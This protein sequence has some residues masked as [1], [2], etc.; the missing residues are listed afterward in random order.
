MA[1]PTANQHLNASRRINTRVMPAYVSGLSPKRSP[2]ATG[3]NNWYDASAIT[4]TSND[5]TVQTWSDLSGNARD[6]AQATAGLRPFYYTQALNGKPG[7]WFNNNRSMT[8]T[9]TTPAW[10]STVGTL[11]IALSVHG[12]LPTPIGEVPFSWTNGVDEYW[13]YG[14]ATSYIGVMRSA[15]L[16]G[17]SINFT[18]GYHVITVL[19]GASAYNVYD[20]GATLYTGSSS[21]GVPA[22]GIIGRNAGSAAFFNGF[23]FEILFYNTE[24]DAATL[25]STWNY[26]KWKWNIG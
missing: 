18:G 22:T 5:A 17:A 6:A 13:W 20:N 23:I 1:I 2:L 10:G 7:L 3:L 19:S 24:H 16:E 9:M 14:S 25:Q 21:W 11:Y 15:R 4:G 26:L 12:W 8:I